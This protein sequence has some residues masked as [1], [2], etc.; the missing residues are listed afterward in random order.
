MTHRHNMLVTMLGK[1]SRNV[2]FSWS[3]EPRF[4][5]TKSDIHRNRP[6]ALVVGPDGNLVD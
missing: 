6:D 1:L 5:D 4:S 3:A 2:N